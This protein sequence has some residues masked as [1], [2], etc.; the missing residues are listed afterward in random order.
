MIPLL[1][2]VN[3]SGTLDSFGIGLTDKLF[4][5]LIYGILGRIGLF[6]DYFESLCPILAAICFMMALGMAMFKVFLQVADLRSE[7]IKLFMSFIIY[8][9]ML[10]AFPMAV[11]GIMTLAS[12]MGYGAVFSTG[13]YSANVTELSGKGT[14]KADFYKW[15]EENCGDLFSFDD[16]NVENM[17]ITGDHAKKALN[18][19]LIDAKSGFMD[20]NKAFKF[21]TGFARLYFGMCPK[22]S[23]ISGAASFLICLVFLISWCISVFVCFK[24]LLKYVTTLVEYFALKGFGILFVPLSL[25]EGTKSY[26]SNLIKAIGSMTIKMIVTFSISFLAIMLLVDNLESIYLSNKVFDA[27]KVGSFGIIPGCLTLVFESL[28]INLLVDSTD[29]IAN[30]LE[31]G[32]PSIGLGDF[33]KSA[34]SAAAAGVLGGMAGV[35]M[36]KAMMGG[37]QALGS[38]A[39]NFAQSGGGFEG[40]KSAM[41]SL[42]KGMASGAKE[43]G[44][45]LK[46]HIGQMGNLASNALGING[47]SPFNDLSIAMRG[48]NPFGNGG[49]NGGEKEGVPSEGSTSG[50]SGNNGGSEGSLSQNGSSGSIES[51]N[52]SDGGAASSKST[53]EN[54]KK[55]GNSSNMAQGSDKAIS[56]SKAEG[57]ASSSSPSTSSSHSSNLRDTKND[58]ANAD[59]QTKQDMLDSGMVGIYGSADTHL[60]KTKNGQEKRVINDTLSDKMMQTANRFSQSDDSLKRYIA[61]PLGS[62]AGFMKSYNERRNSLNSKGNQKGIVSSLAGATKDRISNSNAGKMFNTL[63]NGGGVRDGLHEILNNANGKTANVLNNGKSSYVTDGF[64]NSYNKTNL[65]ESSYNVD[66]N[67]SYDRNGSNRVNAVLTQRHGKAIE[68]RSQAPTDNDAVSFA[69]DATKEAMNNKDRG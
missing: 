20:L 37:R 45:G 56:S 10:W 21:M 34:G 59:A 3:T 57:E 2:Q 8:V 23:I 16:E 30:F 62:M 42:A 64:N 63:R 69:K 19:K 52:K 68:D 36:G 41:G 25:W 35:G 5:H 26:T 47:G 17:D 22:V 6:F 66:Q 40:A 24:I 54:D 39:A 9:F 18:F 58:F 60:E 13:L 28:F 7:V 53:S 49:K 55:S 4:N 46:N 65:G 31:G 50:S 48:G 51:D 14:S 11:K 67:G 61:N 1:L 43:F 33:A 15:L 12:S 27:G 32:S 29:K 44:S 38:A